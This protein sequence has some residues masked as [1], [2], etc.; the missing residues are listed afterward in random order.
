MPFCLHSSQVH[1]ARVPAR[2]EHTATPPLPRLPLRMPP[3]RPIDHPKWNPVWEGVLE[4]IR[5][6]AVE[7]VAH[8]GGAVGGTVRAQ[9]A[10]VDLQPVLPEEQR[11]HR[12]LQ[13]VRAVGQAH[14]SIPSAGDLVELEHR[15][16]HLVHIWNGGG[17]RV[18]GA[19]AAV[20][21]PGAGGWSRRPTGGSAGR[22]AANSAA[23]VA[24][25][26]HA[27]V[28]KEVVHGEV[29]RVQPPGLLLVLRT[30]LLTA[31][32]LQLL[33]AQHLL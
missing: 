11:Q 30:L 23:L 31:A 29:L 20:R 27:V 21:I 15:Q 7:Q 32:Q 25:P 9:R 4:L 16:A 13:A 24:D 10:G 33:H 12:R 3:L 17:T 26:L 19:G 18:G 28:R 5:E 22:G 6:E 2:V 14:D 8:E 1:N